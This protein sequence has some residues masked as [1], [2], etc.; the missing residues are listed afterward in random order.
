MNF[1]TNAFSL[2]MVSADAVVKI[3]KILEPAIELE[4][5]RHQ[6]SMTNA[7]G[8]VDTDN[9]VRS[10]L[11]EGGVNIEPGSRINI[12]LEPGDICIVAQLTG[13]RLPEGA[14]ELPLGA[15]IEFRRVEVIL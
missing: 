14:T 12:R 9:I 1:L 10:L 2:Q 6:G 5:L 4:S 3:S 15:R 8:H 11:S 7:I 13:G